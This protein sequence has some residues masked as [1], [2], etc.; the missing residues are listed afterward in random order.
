MRQLN[1]K[2]QEKVV[3]VRVTETKKMK[4]SGLKEK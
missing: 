2:I 1:S 4:R 3:C